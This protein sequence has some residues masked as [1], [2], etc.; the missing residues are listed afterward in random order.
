MGERLDSAGEREVNHVLV[1]LYHSPPQVAKQRFCAKEGGACV[2]KP[3]K[4]AVAEFYQ[5]AARLNKSSTAHISLGE[6]DLRGNELPQPTELAD[7]SG[8]Q[9]ALYVD[10]D[11]ARPKLAPAVGEPLLAGVELPA[12]RNKL[13]QLAGNYLKAE[14]RSEMTRALSPEPKQK[15]AGKKAKGEATPDAKGEAKGAATGE[16]DATQFEAAAA[17]AA[18]ADGGGEE[19]AKPPPPPAPPRKKSAPRKKPKKGQAQAEGCEVCGL[20]V[21]ELHEKLVATKRELEAAHT[22]RRREAVEKVQKAQTKRWLKQE[23]SVALAAA[24]E[25]RVDGLCESTAWVD[26]AC[27]RNNSLPSW[28]ADGG[29]AEQH[30]AFRRFLPPTEPKAPVPS[31]EPN[32]A[33]MAKNL[34]R[35]CSDT[36]KE[37]CRAVVEDHIEPIMRAVL[38]SDMDGDA[39]PSVCTQLFSGCEEE[40][41]A[42]FAPKSDGAAAA[43]ASAEVDEDAAAAAAAEAYFAESKEEL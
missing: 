27:A 23:Y 10:K 3:Y 43:E 33:E 2:A 25:E 28:A 30:C 18:K 6:M 34:K 42:C 9:F 16:F 19:E 38:D 32:P 35:Q 36:A 29:G 26:L 37:R 31:D 11:K 41:A 7:P 1:M 22:A 20:L 12:L 5:L 15:G 40:R 17:A 39:D 21:R 13:K 8:L 24:L 4:A 14:A